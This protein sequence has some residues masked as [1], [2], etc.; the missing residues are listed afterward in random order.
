M[1]A[2]MKRRRL[3]AMVV[4]GA[5][6]TI[7]PIVMRKLRPGEAAMMPTMIESK[8]GVTREEA[9]ELRAGGAQGRR[10]SSERCRGA[11]SAGRSRVRCRQR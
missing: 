7:G 11:R 3:S 9:L 1:D 2:Y 5:S 6:L 10:S 8:V 4:D